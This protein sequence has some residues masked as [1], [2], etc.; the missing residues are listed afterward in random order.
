MNRLARTTGML[1]FTIAAA[2]S[3]PAS[4]GQAARVGD[5]H[6]CPQLTGHVP[7]VGGPILPPGAPNVLICGKPAA[8]VG[9]PVECKGP[10][11][12][13]VKGSSTVMIGGKPAA[14]LGDL[15]AHGGTLTSGCGNVMIGD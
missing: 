9:N 11:D 10:Q 13:I 7:H 15:T 4:S 1:I 2:T 3:A 6:T 5:N 8:V 14:R 12:S